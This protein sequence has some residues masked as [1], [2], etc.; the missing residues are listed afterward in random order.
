MYVTCKLL[1]A[2]AWK[3]FF[4][5][6]RGQEGDAQ[7]LYSPSSSPLA[8]K[9]PTDPEAGRE[10]KRILFQ[11]GGQRCP[12]EVVKQLLGEDSLVK[13]RRKPLE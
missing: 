3:R 8:A 1:A 13:V 12:E 9:D 7:C 10:V 5:K 2:V 6:V 4:E 11:A